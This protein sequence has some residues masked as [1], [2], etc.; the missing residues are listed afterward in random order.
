MCRSMCCSMRSLSSGSLVRPSHFNKCAVVVELMS[1]VNP[2]MP[3][4]WNITRVPIFLETMG[5]MSTMMASARLTAP[6]KPAQTITKPSFQ[7]SA[8]PTWRRGTQR[9]ITVRA[10]ITIT[11]IYITKSQTM[12]IIWMCSRRERQ[13][14][15]N[16]SPANKKTT[17]LPMNST[18]SQTV[19]TTS[20][21]TK[22]GQM[23]PASARPADTRLSMPLV[24]SSFSAMKKQVYPQHIVTMTCTMASEWPR[25]KAQQLITQ[26]ATDATMKPNRADS[27]IMLAKNSTTWTGDKDAPSKTFSIRVKQTTAVPS[28]KRLSPEMIIVS[29]GDTPK[30]LKRATTA[31]GSVADRMAPK[32]KQM[33]QSQP[34]G[35]MKW[36][37]APMRTVPSKTPGPASSKI[38]QMH[39]FT[40]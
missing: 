18:A 34:Y 15:A 28:L 31:T 33:G 20:L 7:S 38:C 6:R 32:T 21:E 24:D 27:T 5:S 22:R 36:L 8:A 11:A 3:P 14:S 17:V 26:S 1:K 10:R 12:S 37:N 40:W 13:L 9:I 29:L 30:V 35:K 25:S 23:D 19:C 4:T 2:A 39:I 16:K